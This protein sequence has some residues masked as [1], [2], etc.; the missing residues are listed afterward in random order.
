MRR[1]GREWIS[2]SAV[3]QAL[4]TGQRA[5][6]RTNP[7]VRVR[8]ESDR[9]V[10]CPP[11]IRAVYP[12]A[13]WFDTLLPACVA[14]ARTSLIVRCNACPH[15]CAV[16]GRGACHVPGGDH[17]PRPGVHRDPRAGHHARPELDHR[18]DGIRLHVLS[19]G[20]R[21]VRDSDRALGR[22]QGHPAG[23]GAHRRVVV[24]PDRRDRRR[25][26][27]RTAAGHPVPVRCRGSR[28][29]GLC[30]AHL[31]A[32]DP[33]TRARHRAGHLLRRRASG[34]RPDSGAGAV[35]A[36]VPVL[37]PDLRLLRR[38]GL[39]VGSGLAGLVP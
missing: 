21:A 2:R 37:A 24:V 9:R 39:R 35:A 10:M 16:Q 4:R 28:R 34:R 18:A 22:S 26:E 17:S 14:G 38:P 5:Q 13:A 29:V 8:V 23:A 6:P 1:G 36:P 3:V 27:L 12:F 25:H 7:A 32:M 19:T 33:A 30:R 31:L 11:E 15:P 20:V